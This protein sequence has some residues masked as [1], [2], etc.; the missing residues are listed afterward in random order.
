M[1]RSTVI[2]WPVLERCLSILHAQRLPYPVILVVYKQRQRRYQRRFTNC[3]TLGP[4]FHRTQVDIVLCRIVPSSV[5]ASCQG[6]CPLR[7]SGVNLVRSRG[8]RESGRR[9]FLFQP[10]KVRL[11]RQKFWRP[12][13]SRQL[14]KLSFLPKY[15]HFHLLHLHCTFL[16]NFSLFLIKT[17]KEK[18]CP[19]YFLCNIGYIVF[20]HPFTTPYDP[21]DPHNPSAQNLGIATPPTPSGLTPM[22]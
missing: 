22:H 2:G 21:C 13:F 6:Q 11:S 4:E 18:R 12:F 14:K 8:G 17:T 16:A 15:S 3:T 10:K 7:N 9:N 1:F 5:S 20:R 19:T